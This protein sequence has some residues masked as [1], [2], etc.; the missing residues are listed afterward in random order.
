MIA[1]LRSAGMDRGERMVLVM[2][3]SALGCVVLSLTFGALGALAY[4]PAAS[5]TLLKGGVSLAQ[6]RPLHTTFASAWLFLAAAAGAYAYLNSEFGEST[7]GDAWRFRIQMVLWGLAGLGAIFTLPFGIVSGREYLA[8]HPALSLMIWVG[9]ALFCWTFISKVWRGFFAR[10]VYVYMWSVGM[11]FFLWTFAEGH[12]YLLPWMKQRPLADLHVQWKS[13]GT[14]VASFNQMV[15]AGLLYIGVQKSGDERLGHSRG[16]FALF[17]IG[18]LNSFTNYVHH[19]YHLPQAEF[20]KWIS[21]VV[22]M[23][24]VIILVIVIKEVVQALRAKPLAPA[25]GFD[26]STALFGLTKSWN[27]CLLFLA[28]LISIPPLN[29]LIHGTHVVMAHGMGS[30]LAIDSYILL[31]SFAFILGSLFPDP[32][33]GEVLIH[34]PRVQSSIRFLNVFLICLVLLLVVEGLTIGLTRY[35]GSPAPE[36]LIAFPPFFLVFGLGVAFFFLRLIVCW[37]PL[38]LAPAAFRNRRSTHSN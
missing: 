22:S 28:L 4:L 13:C 3:A 19:T 33:V 23:L 38:M 9:W 35:M 12:A 26:A 30:E 2:I 37:L 11:L 27:M 5:E 29:T 20:L 32:K 18:L 16:A 31:G 21:F 1:K 10:P 6:L 34:A 36:W 25:E 24:E 14:L 8:L 17:G 15:Y 7:A